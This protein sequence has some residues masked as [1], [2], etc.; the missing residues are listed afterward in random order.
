MIKNFLLASSSPY[1]AMLMKQLGLPFIQDKPDIDETPIATETAEAY[2]QRL[3]T[4]KARALL[5]THA[6]DWIIGS[7]QTCIINGKITGKPGNKAKAL[8]QLQSVQGKSVIFLTGLCLL[9]NHTQETYSLVEPFEVHFRNLPDQELERYLDLEKP[10]DC[11]GSF[12][13]EGLGI[14]LFERL[15]GRDPNSLIGLPLIGLCDLMRQA[16]LSPLNFIEEND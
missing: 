6:V 9:N 1:R 5:N 15:S 12:K 16:G 2:V 3:A 10:F 11:A 8:Q 13:M 7:D 4:E 14:H